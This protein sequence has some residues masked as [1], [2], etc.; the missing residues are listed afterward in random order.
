MDVNYPLETA[1]SHK[2]TVKYSLLFPVLS[3]LFIK[4]Y[5]GKRLAC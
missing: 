2:Y 3:V 5:F 1:K 4:Y